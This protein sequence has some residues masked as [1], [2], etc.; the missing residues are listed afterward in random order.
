MLKGSYQKV[1]LEPIEWNEIFAI[2]YLIENSYIEYKVNNKRKKNWTKL[3]YIYPEKVQMVNKH[4]KY[5][6]KLFIREIFI[7]SWDN[8]VIIII[9]KE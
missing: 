6:S 5:F 4:M 8:I 3:I 2:L 9:E 1:K 7:K